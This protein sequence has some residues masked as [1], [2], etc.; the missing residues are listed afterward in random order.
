MTRTPRRILSW[1]GV[2]ALLIGLVVGYTHLP[3]ADGLGG[4]LRWHF[5]RQ[6]LSSDEARRITLLLHSADLRTPGTAGA[7]L[8]PPL[9]DADTGA[10]AVALQALRDQLELHRARQGASYEALRNTF[11][12]W[13]ANATTE[14]RVANLQCTLE[15]ARLATDP[16]QSVDQATA[17]YSTDD[18]RWAVA[19]TRC[20]G[21][22]RDLAC[23]RVLRLAELPPADL[24]P[25]DPRRLAQPAGD[26]D[27]LPPMETLEQRLAV[28]DYYVP[29][30]ATSPGATALPATAAS[31]PTL[32]ATV[33]AEQCRMPREALVDMLT[34][35]IP[36]VRWGAARLLV[37]SGDAN[38]L[39]VFCECLRTGPYAP[40]TDVVMTSVFGPDWRTRGESGSTTRGASPGDSRE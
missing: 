27:T 28:L 11:T 17:T 24:D 32:D 29:P 34:D 36:D 33:F 14:R 19:G 20:N 4:E 5:G 9:Q 15:C 10:Q 23:R 25:P 18:W 3:G 40:G 13:L 7:L 39:P 22:A 6:P 35:P 26:D 38:A 30:R 21:S 8:T 37:I 12:A 31:V 1:T 2:L 16:A